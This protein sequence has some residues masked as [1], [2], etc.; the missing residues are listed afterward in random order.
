MPPKVKAECLQEIRG[1]RT[2]FQKDSG[3]CPEL[4][5]CSKMAMTPMIRALLRCTPEEA[6][7][8]ICA[9]CDEKQEARERKRVL[10]KKSL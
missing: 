3:S 4:Y 6:M 10:L 1:V 7:Q 9:N 2:V 8:S 5:E